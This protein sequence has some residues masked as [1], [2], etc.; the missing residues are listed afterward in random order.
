MTLTEIGEY[1]FKTAHEVIS[2]LKPRTFKWLVNKDT[3]RDDGTKYDNPD[4]YGF[5]AHEVQEAIPRATDLGIVQGE[6]DGEDYQSMDD[7][8]LNP[9]IIKAI[10]E[11]SA[12][13][14]ALE[15]AS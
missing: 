15:N 6:K 3:K 13:V 5:I 7:T 8:K 4:V 10:Q 1:V 12:K 9:L 14:T 2:K 11:L